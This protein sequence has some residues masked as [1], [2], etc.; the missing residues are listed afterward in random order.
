MIDTENTDLTG[1]DFDHQMRSYIELEEERT[2]PTLPDWI[3]I[4]PKVNK[5]RQHAIQEAI[6]KAKHKL[7]NEKVL[8]CTRYKNQKDNTIPVSFTEN[9][10]KEKL[11]L[12]HVKRYGD[13][14][15]IAYKTDSNAQNNR[16]LYLC[17]KNECGVEK[18]ISTTIR[19]TKLGYLEFYDYIKCSEYMSNFIMYEPLS[20]PLK[21]PEF[22]P[23]PTSVIEWQK[24]DC[25]DM[26]ILLCSLL[27]GVGYDAYC[28]IGTAPYEITL[29]NEGLMDNPYLDVGLKDLEPKPKEPDPEPTGDYAP[30]KRA[31][32]FSVYDDKV[33][34][35]KLQEMEKAHKAENDV[36]DD[37]EPDRLPPDEFEGKRVHC[38]VL[39]KKGARG[40]EE[41]TFIEPSTGRTWVLKDKNFPYHKVDQVFNNK[42]FWIN[43]K[44]HKDISDIKFENMDNGEKDDWEYVMMDTVKF[45]NFEAQDDDED[46]HSTGQDIKKT[47]LGQE[48]H[49]VQTI[50]KEISHLVDMPLPWPPKLFIEKD[51]FLRGSPMGEVTRFYKKSRVDTYTKYLQI[52]GLTTRLTIYEDFNR[53]LV[54]EIRSIYSNRKNNLIV[55]RRF[56][57]E[58]KTIE[59]YKPNFKP[60]YKPAK[61]SKSSEAA[62]M[63]WPHWRRIEEIDRRQRIID[64][65]PYRHEDGLIK[66]ID[67]LGVDWPEHEEKIYKT[68]EFFEGRD[69]FMTYRSFKYT[70]VKLPNDH[71]SFNFTSCHDREDRDDGPDKNKDDKETKL[72]LLRRSEKYIVKMQQ[73]FEKNPRKDGHEQVAKIVKGELT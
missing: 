30:E 10:N 33:F 28:V 7:I 26:S 21:Y 29:K 2:H 32:E 64:F 46:H 43:L 63:N 56:P 41:N 67:E 59:Y 54:K 71:G 58:F 6:D 36:L 62:S 15:H 69:D 55:R 3:T 31:N 5:I 23:S 9:T 52:D 4:K 65:Y 12:E 11:I 34:K 53:I 61:T 60:N 35:M 20:N 49:K 17:P 47:G 16:V 66:R 39:V 8:R 14:F 25:F 19:P 37:D 18:F 1:K 48:I 44:M 22:I 51:K 40:V 57:M 27:I 13:Q 70:E 45:P 42:N 72:G 50:I 38:W 73:R 24:G 68:K